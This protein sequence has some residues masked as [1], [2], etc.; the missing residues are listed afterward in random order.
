MGLQE[1]DEEMKPANGPPLKRD[2]VESAPTETSTSGV[3]SDYA[4]MMDNPQSVI[5]A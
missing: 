2:K 1:K 5:G 4:E 3:C